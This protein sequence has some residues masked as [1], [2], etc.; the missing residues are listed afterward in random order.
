MTERE[1]GKEVIKEVRFNNGRPPG[2]VEDPNNPGV[3]TSPKHAD[4]LREQLTG[5]IADQTALAK[6]DPE[7]KALSDELAVV[8]LPEYDLGAAKKAEPTRF[9]IKQ[10]TRL[11]A[12]LHSRGWRHHPE[13]EEVRWVPT[14]DGQ[15]HDL[16]IHITKS[17]D[18]TWP[19]PNPEDFYD[20]EKIDLSQ[21]P[22]GEWVAAH[23]CGANAKHPSKAK[24]HADVVRQL[25]VKIEE[26]NA[27]VSESS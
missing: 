1:D 12:Y 15:A 8:H 4:W 26:A 18:G 24:A 9:E 23:P 25:L 2:Y 17:E 21:T 19:T 16:G 14:P 6:V 27:D 22:G 7:V 5:A 3:W 10:P 13:C 11:A 20:A